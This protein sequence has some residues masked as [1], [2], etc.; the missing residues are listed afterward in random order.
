MISIYGPFYRGSIADAGWEDLTDEVRSRWLDGDR[1]GA[2]E[3]VT[4]DLLDDLVAAGTPEE[5]R[6]QVERFEVIDRVDAIQIG[7][8]SWIDFKNRSRR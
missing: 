8:P 5:A 4:D 1:E 3:T 2:T 6:K 7:F